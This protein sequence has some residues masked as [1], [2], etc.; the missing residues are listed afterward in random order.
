M[1]SF[2]LTILWAPALE[3]A[4]ANFVLQLTIVVP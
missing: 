2:Q 3:P 1:L 4:L